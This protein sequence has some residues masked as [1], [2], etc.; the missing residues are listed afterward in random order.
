MRHHSKEVLSI[1]H[2]NL[3]Y[4][5]FVAHLRKWQVQT[6]VDVR[7]IPYSKHVPHF[8]YEVL[9]RK[10][11][12][13]NLAYEYLGNQLG[14][15][16]VRVRQAADGVADYR[17]QIAADA[18]DDG[19]DRLLE[20]AGEGCVAVMCTESD[21]YRCHRHTVLAVELAE[22]GLSTQHILKSGTLRNAFEAPIRTKQPSRWV[23]RD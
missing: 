22:R 2:S 20:L 23:Q 10:L 5:T 6:V 7:S 9:K 14:S 11:C 12:K 21:P 19:I 17:R 1:G 8:N 13:S 3:S 16:N 18:F 15:H 4:R